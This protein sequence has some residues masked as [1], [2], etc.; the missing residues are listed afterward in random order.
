MLGVARLVNLANGTN[1][2][3]AMDV[4]VS[5]VVAFETCLMVMRMVTREG[6]IY[7]YAVDG[8]GGIN[9]VAKFGMFK[10]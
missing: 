8:P 9:F 2:P 10:G 7:G 3:L 5:Q 6:G 4:N 1:V